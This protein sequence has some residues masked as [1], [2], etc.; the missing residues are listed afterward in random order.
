MFNVTAHFLNERVLGDLYNS[1]QA[2]F[3]WTDFICF[4]YIFIVIP[5][6]FL[7]PCTEH[8]GKNNFSPEDQ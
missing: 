5:L 8:L 1:V 2:N 7:N 4:S 6:L 3:K